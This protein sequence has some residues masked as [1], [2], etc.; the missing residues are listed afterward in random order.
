MGAFK[1]KNAKLLTMIVA[2][3]VLV[4]AAYLA[5]SNKNEEKAMTEAQKE[6][7]TQLDKVLLK[8]LDESYPGSVREV[9]KFY[10]K[11]LKSMFNGDV[12]EKQID[13]LID[14][15]RALFDEELLK[16]N[17]YSK[18]VDGRYS[19]IDAYKKNKS[20]MIK[21]V[22][23]ENESVKYW[24]NNGKDM[25]S[26]KAKIYMGGDKYIDFTQEYILRK[27]DKDR[28]KILSWEN[29]TED[30]NEKNEDTDS[31]VNDEDSDK[32]SS[33]D[34]VDE[35]DDGTDALKE[36]QDMINQK[37]SADKKND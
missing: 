20:S 30:I 25:A 29:T 22:V 24:Q 6:N 13:K 17:E 1:G 31:K 14:K 12:T 5:V 15:E 21:Y 34:S 35:T 19:E 37:E 18:F 28:W 32:G 27:D 11:I 10:C 23:G 4:V 8:D 3:A 33:D 16:L 9:I 26:I 36:M 2:I 7:I